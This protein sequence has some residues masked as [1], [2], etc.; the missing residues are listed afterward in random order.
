MSRS[1]R[2][3][4]RRSF[5]HVLATSALT[6]SAIGASACSPNKGVEPKAS[7]APTQKP[8]VPAPPKMPAGSQLPPGL[9]AENFIVHGLTPLNLETKRDRFTQGPITPVSRAYV[10]SNLPLP[11]PEILKARD[12]WRLEVKGVKKE[13]TLTL[14]MLK[15]LGLESVTAV[16]QCS[17]NGRK[18]FS[19]KA[20]G[21][22]WSVGAAA[23]LIW[24]GVLVADVIKHMGGI[25]SKKKMAFLTAT[26][27]EEIPDGLDPKQ[28]MVE[29]SIPLAKGLK[30]ALLAWEVNGEPIS[31]ERG[32]PL[33][34]VVPG[35][36][37]VNFVKYVKTLTVAEQPS[38]AKIQ[39]TSYRVRPVGQKADPSQ[40]SM[41]EMAVKSFLIEPP[42]GEAMTGKQRWVGV[43][44]SGKAPIV[45]VEVS[46]DGGKTWQKAS[47]ASP[48][49]GPYA[50]RVFSLE[51]KLTS[52]SY[53][54]VS[55]AKDASGQVQ[56]QKR[57]E[58]HRGYGNNSWQD[59]G[60][61]VKVR[62]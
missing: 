2:P 27:A 56:P 12:A 26:G 39:K 19:H 13:G 7:A 40:P 44:F 51:T 21:S 59:M 3:E 28:L 24:T 37:G 34:L 29:R 20:S 47:L 5:L 50:W 22:P 23:N 18:F 8:T 17:G 43:A 9:S 46:T 52:G 4:S 60:I 1:C 58:N 11:S 31:L 25:D 49:L 62:T 30:D 42:Q 6:G 55:R 35:Y 14:R 54:L 57:S 61:D 33:R 15:T 32:G 53:R 16:L 45:A 38:D 48:D 36:Y 41:W 10:R